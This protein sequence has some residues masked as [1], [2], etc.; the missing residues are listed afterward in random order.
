MQMHR[1]E[2]CGKRQTTLSGPRA[3]TIRSYAKTHQ[4]GAALSL[5]LGV[6]GGLGPMSDDGQ[7]SA[8]STNA[9]VMGEVLQGKAL[10]SQ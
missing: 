10:G 1:D 8:T 7:G 5:F 4:K 2:S 3:R 6:I 9:D